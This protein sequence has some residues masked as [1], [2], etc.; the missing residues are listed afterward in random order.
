MSDTEQKVLR[1]CTNCGDEFT[2]KK[3]SFA[4]G[5]NCFACGAKASKIETIRSVDAE[6]E[7]GSR[8]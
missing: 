1:R 6:T 5:Y 2:A 7:E 4:S 3:R 8:R